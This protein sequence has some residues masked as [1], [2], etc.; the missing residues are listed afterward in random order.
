MDPHLAAH[1]GPSALQSFR[2]VRAQRQ[3]DRT[4]CGRSRRGHVAH[5]R[6]L[7]RGHRGV[8]IGLLGPRVPGLDRGRRGQA[9]V[10]LRS[11]HRSL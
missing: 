9:H 7:V 2:L 3:L 4:R 5:W 6:R 10:H 8:N 1:E 11:L